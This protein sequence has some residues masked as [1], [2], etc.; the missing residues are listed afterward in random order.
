MAGLRAVF[1]LALP[2]F[3]VQPPHRRCRWV[4]DLQPVRRSACPI[5]RAKPLGHDAL[6]AERARVLVDDGTIAAERLI[7]GDAVM[8]KPQ[9]PGQPALSVLD[10]LGAHVLAVHLEEIERAEDGATVATVAADQIE[11]R[12]PVVVARDR[13][14][15]DDA[16]LD[17]KRR[18]R[19]YG[20]REAVG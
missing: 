17:R 15:V 9:Q 3:F 19:G 18:D 10:R 2:I 1:G 20:E 8:R 16:G 5:R 12:Q 7:K 14:A 11:Y 6:A 13:F 4:L